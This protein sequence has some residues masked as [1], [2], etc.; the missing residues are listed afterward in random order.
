MSKLIARWTDFTKGEAGWVD[1]ARVPD[2]FLTGE[3]A[4]V[5][6]DGAVGPRSGI[7]DLGATSI[8]TPTLQDMGYVDLGLG[9]IEYVWVRAQGKLARVAVYD[10]TGKVLSGQAF[11]LTTGTFA[12]SLQGDSVEYSPSI[13][14]FTQELGTCYKCDWA[15]GANGTLTAIAGSP[16]GSCIEI[17]GSFLVVA[18]DGVGGLH[19]NR[20][21]WSKQ[22][23][24]TTWPAANFLDLG[25]IGNVGGG[26]IGG[27]AITSIRKVKD[28]LLVFMDTGQLFVITGTLGEN[29]VVREFEPGDRMSGPA[30]PSSTARSRDGAVWW[31]RREEV[32]NSEDQ[33]YDF[34]SA[35]PV[36]YQGGQRSEA[37]ALAGYLRQLAFKSTRVSQTLA[38]PGRSDGSV[39]LLDAANRALLI[40]EGVWSRHVWGTET[41]DT[42]HLRA[43]VGSRGDCYMMDGA[44]T[45]LRAWQF[46]LERPPWSYRGSAQEPLPYDSSDFGSVIEGPPA[47]FATPE[48]R[49][50]DFS[51]VVV[52]RVEV[53][54]T[55]HS[56]H[57]TGGHNSFDVFIQQYDAYLAGGEGIDPGN[58]PPDFDSGSGA[59]PVTLPCFS[60]LATPAYYDEVA[61]ADPFNLRRRV[62]FFP[63]EG[64]I[65]PAPGIRV[66]IE[67]MIGVSIHEIA[68][69]GELNAAPAR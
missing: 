10:A 53:L 1:K 3:N 62:K 55:T 23:D 44:M 63:E 68:V 54:F 42:D 9:G 48:F 5:Y 47:W 65:L 45:G 49:T 30:F 38:V 16:A 59:D 29:E 7:L 25:N 24:F 67:E 40:R 64:A 39:V 12:T 31:T 27:P 15:T 41:A 33:A 19:R 11:H 21:H 34:P 66:L 43:T 26:W 61:P 14:L 36:K 52:E 37:I 4:I 20:V 2:G 57:D 18:G 28:Q 51:H 35:V 32:P 56:D 13:T 6:R 50:P 8:P 58:F 69:F 60:D 46:E 22:D 17:F